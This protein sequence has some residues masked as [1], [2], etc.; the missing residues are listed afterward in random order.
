MTLEHIVFND[1]NT[2]ISELKSA[3]SQL[4][5]ISFID[6]SYTFHLSSFLLPTLLFYANR[7]NWPFSHQTTEQNQIREENVPSC[8]SD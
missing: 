2:L 4:N 6:S 8:V 1:F 5:A 7:F 3:A